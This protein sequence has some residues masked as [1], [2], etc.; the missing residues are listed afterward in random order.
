M[1]AYP[2]E[3]EGRHGFSRPWWELYAWRHLANQPIKL[4][5]NA[6]PEPQHSFDPHLASSAG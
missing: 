5:A 3:S 1:F 6:L 2:E 4:F